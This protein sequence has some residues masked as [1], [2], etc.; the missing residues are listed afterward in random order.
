MNIKKANVIVSILC[1]VLGL[2]IIFISSGYPSAEAYGTGVPGPGLWP[3]VISV[4]MLGCAALLMMK[5][6]KM[7]PEENEEV[8]LWSADTRRVYIS[9]LVLL[10]YTIILE[11]VGFILSTIAMLFLFI[12]WFAKKSWIKNLV[13][14]VLVT[15]IIYA[16]FKWVLNVP[17]DFGFFAL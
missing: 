17:I 9:M 2:G 11:Y 3:I 1:A 12:Q 5:T 14:S 8:V 7:K 6:L 10:I 4:V 16:V 15:M 13:I